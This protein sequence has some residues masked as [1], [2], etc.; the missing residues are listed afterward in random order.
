MLISSASQDIC[1]IPSFKGSI[2]IQSSSGESGDWAG[3]K[4][5]RTNNLP[6]E[7]QAFN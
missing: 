5:T 7:Q 4:E 3:W 1:S 6:E 2:Q